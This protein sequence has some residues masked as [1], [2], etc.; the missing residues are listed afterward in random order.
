M[1]RGFE[2]QGFYLSLYPPTI[3][4]FPRKMVWQSKVPP[5]VPFFLWFA[6]LGKILTT[7]NL[8]KRRIIVLDWCYILM[9]AKG[10]GSQ[11]IIFFFIAP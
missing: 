5:G 9:C 2:I 4:S 6:S 3:I 7:N 11:W 10:V 1:S 8:Q